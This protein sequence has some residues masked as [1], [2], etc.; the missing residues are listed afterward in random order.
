MLIKLLI[1]T[2]LKNR[3]IVIVLRLYSHT[4]NLGGVPAVDHLQPN[5]LNPPF[6]LSVV[7]YFFNHRDRKDAT[8]SASLRLSG[9]A[10]I[11]VVPTQSSN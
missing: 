11:S 8:F 6:V 3:I 7:N 1:L 2:D 10:L 5:P 4:Q 9:S